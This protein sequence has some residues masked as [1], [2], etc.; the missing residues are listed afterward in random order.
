MLFLN[1][2]AFFQLGQEARDVSRVVLEVPIHT[3][4]DLPLGVLKAGSHGCGLAI[5]FPEADHLY[6]TVMVV[7]P[8]QYFKCPVAAAVVHEDDFVWF[9]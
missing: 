4:D 1:I 2:V 3:D 8:V 6:P 5:V 7:Y 9:L